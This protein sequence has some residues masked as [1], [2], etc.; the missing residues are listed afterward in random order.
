MRDSPGFKIMN[1]LESRGFE[2]FSFDP[3]FKNDLLEKYLKENFLKNLNVINVNC[4]EENFLKK[5]SCLCIVQHH[6]KSKFQIKDIYEKSLVPL[7]YDCQNQLEKNN[8]SK[9]IL[10][11]L[12]CTY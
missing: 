5:I 2:V 8:D 12:G 11:S 4:L 6:T 7:I 1:E 3:Y 10:Q 9:T